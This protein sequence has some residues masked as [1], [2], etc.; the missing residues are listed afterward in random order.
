M[1]ITEMVLPPTTLM[2]TGVAPGAKLAVYNLGQ[3]FIFPQDPGVLYDIQR[4]VRNPFTFQ[5]HFAL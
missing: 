3:E 1:S 4:S 5:E 2:T